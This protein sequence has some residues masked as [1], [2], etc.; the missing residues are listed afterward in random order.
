MPKIV[1]DNQEIECR[2]GI[3]VLQAALD[4][5]AGTEPKLREL[6]ERLEAGEANGIFDF[7]ETKAHSPL[8]RAYQWAD[9][10]AYVNHVEL[11]RKARGAEMP[12]SFWTDQRRSA[13]QVHAV[14]VVRVAVDGDF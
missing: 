1:I 6:A 2:E 12:E 11:V 8:P 4:D 14:A 9:G 3:P 7:D 10:S 5:W 13:V